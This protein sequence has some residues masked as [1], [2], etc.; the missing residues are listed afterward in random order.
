MVL[1]PPVVASGLVPIFYDATFGTVCGFCSGYTLKKIGRGVAL[2]FGLAF[3][4]LQ[5]SAFNGLINPIDWSPIKLFL[6]QLFDQ[7]GDGSFGQS[8]FELIGWKLFSLLQVGLPSTVG[9]GS[10]LFLGLRHG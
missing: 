6:E 2:A 10:G 1:F 8:D 3:V 9:F 7:D 4:G 5:L